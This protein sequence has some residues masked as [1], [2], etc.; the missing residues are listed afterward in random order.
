MKKLL[1]YFKNKFI[2]ASTVFLI[3]TLFLDDNDIFSI[4]SRNSK[5]T[6][7]TVKR[8]LMVSDLEKT[9]SILEKLKYKSEVEKYARENKFFKKDDE[10]VFVIF[11]E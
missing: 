3:Y 4:I 6:E 9:T 5:L 1:P 10:D 11:Y 7:L 8:K 2:L